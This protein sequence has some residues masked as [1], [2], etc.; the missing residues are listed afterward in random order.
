MPSIAAVPYACAM[1]GLRSTLV[2][3]L[4][5]AFLQ[6]PM[7]SSWAKA[8]HHGNPGALA[9]CGKHNEVSG[10]LATDGEQ[11]VGDTQFAPELSAEAADGVPPAA[12]A[13]Q[14]APVGSG[15]AVVCCDLTCTPTDAVAG[16]VS[17]FPLAAK[18]AVIPLSPISTCGRV[19]GVDPPPPRAIAS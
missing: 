14:S 6:G 5:A 1:N 19:T 12:S 8:A 7:A 2:M 3:L 15:I 9:D 10:R 16:F 4:T 13:N 17:R 11:T 18:D